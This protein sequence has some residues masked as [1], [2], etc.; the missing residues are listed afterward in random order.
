MAKL[1]VDDD[2]NNKNGPNLTVVATSS[3]VGNAKPN[4]EEET[5]PHKDPSA[6]NA[7]ILYVQPAK[8]SRRRGEIPG[9]AYLVLYPPMPPPGK[10]KEAAALGMPKKESE[11]DGGSRSRS[12]SKGGGEAPKAENGSNPAK[13][14]PKPVEE[15]LTTAER[16]RLIARARLL[17]QSVSDALSDFCDRDAAASRRYGG[18]RAEVGRSQKTWKENLSVVVA[19]SSSSSSP[20]PPSSFPGESNPR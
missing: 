16:S 6:V 11:A 8:K 4:E 2:K 17:L 10:A 20:S 19:S 13:G 7:R 12:N 1:S 5:Q 15:P 14:S 3:T 9:T 18:C